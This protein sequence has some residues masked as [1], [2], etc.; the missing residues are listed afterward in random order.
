MVALSD[1]LDFVSLVALPKNTLLVAEWYQDGTRAGA[2]KLA[3]VRSTLKAAKLSKAPGAVLRIYPSGAEFVTVRVKPKDNGRVMQFSG[4]E[5][6]KLRLP[7]ETESKT[8]A[9]VIAKA[10]GVHAAVPASP[11]PKQQQKQLLSP[12]LEKQHAALK[13]KRKSVEVSIEVAFGLKGRR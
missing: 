3:K 1:D 8:I 9:A 12:A 5:V 10:N 7:N 2:A 6:Y 4:R 13:P 11:P